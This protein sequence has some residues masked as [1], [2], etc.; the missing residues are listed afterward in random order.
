MTRPANRSVS[1]P[2]E[3]FSPAGSLDAV[4]VGVWAEMIMAVNE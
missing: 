2:D 1:L 3:A 4:D